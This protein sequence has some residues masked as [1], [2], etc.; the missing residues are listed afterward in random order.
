[1]RGLSSTTWTPNATLFINRKIMSE[2]PLDEEFVKNAKPQVAKARIE[3]EEKILEEI[4]IEDPEEEAA[5][6][7]VANN[8]R[9]T[10]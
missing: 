5:E 10:V 4:E 1:M 6:R 3:L 2:K 9:K 8:R 7:A